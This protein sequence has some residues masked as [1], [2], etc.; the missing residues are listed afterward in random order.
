MAAARDAA[1]VQRRG[2]VRVVSAGWDVLPQVIR[3]A[4]KLVR[5]VSVLT[6]HLRT[7]MPK[8]LAGKA[9]N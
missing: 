2:A 3:R 1:F 4:I 6:G 8:G 9:R 5:D 7:A